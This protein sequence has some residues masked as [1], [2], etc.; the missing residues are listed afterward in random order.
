MNE[1]VGYPRYR[2]V[3]LV[4]ACLSFISL[5]IN[6]ISFAP[7][8]KTIASDLAVDIGRATNL[9][10]VFV[11]AGAIALI[12]AGFLCDRFGVLALLVF[13]TLFGSGAALLMP[14]L[15]G[16]FNAVF[17]LRFLEGMAVG[18]CMATMSPTMAIFF[19]PKEWG[20]VGGLQGTSVAV[21]TALGVGLAPV[22]A[23]AAGGWR[24]MSA[25]LS[26]PGGSPS[27]SPWSSF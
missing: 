15:G 19:P 1:A 5:S 6:M 20:L 18:F 25:W 4:A 2:W 23:Q 26:T 24:P 13:G 11:F 12:I 8:L 7:I 27:P 9:M 14:W 3:V 21:G 16:S 10:A 22:V 17:L